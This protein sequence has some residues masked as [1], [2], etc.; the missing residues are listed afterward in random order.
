MDVLSVILPTYNA[1]Q[2]AL[3]SA[4]SLQT[5]LTTLGIE[6]EIVLVDDGSVPSER[7]DPAA[8]PPRARLVQLPHN[9]GKGCAV[10]AGLGSAQG[11][12]RIFTDVDL[13]YGLD[14]IRKCYEALSRDEVEFVYGDRSFPG[15]GRLVRQ[16]W[17]RKL[18]SAVFRAAVARI[19]GLKPTDTQ[20]GLKGFSGQVADALSTLGRTDHFAF[21][22]EMFRYALDNGLR[23]QAIPVQLVN[24]DVSTVHL[25][26]DS[27]T[28]LRDLVAIRRRANRGEYRADRSI[29]PVL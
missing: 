18:S 16:S 22:V 17:R 14:S 29:R 26:R 10:R 23:V 12:F 6:Y 3:S 20:C 9:R 13:P 24:E 8:L 21:D 7:P 15:S 5:F 4:T 1:G 25:L 2:L 19:V 28:M 11:R 27:P